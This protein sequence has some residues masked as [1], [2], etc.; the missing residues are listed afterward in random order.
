MSRG[1]FGGKYSDSYR[2]GKGGKAGRGPGRSGKR[3]MTNPG[4]G[5]RN[6]PTKGWGASPHNGPAGHTPN[7]GGFWGWLLGE[8]GKGK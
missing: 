7:D 2:Q 8:N 5:N 6:R 1:I 3:A 4:G